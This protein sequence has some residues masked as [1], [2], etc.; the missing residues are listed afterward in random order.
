M[1]EYA[2]QCERWQTASTLVNEAP[3][4]RRHHRRTERLCAALKRCAAAGIGK[5]MEN[6]NITAGGRH[7][8]PFLPVTQFFNVQALGRL[9][10]FANLMMADSQVTVPA[11]RKPA[12][13]MWLSSCRLCNGYESLTAV[14]QKTQLARCSADFEHNLVS[15][16]IA[17]SSAFAKPFHYY[18][19]DWERC[20]GHGNH[21]RDKT[22]KMGST[23]SLS[24][25]GAG[26]IEDEIEPVRSGVGAVCGVNLKSHT[27]R[28]TSLPLGVVA[29]ILRYGFQT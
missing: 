25:F 11:R 26:R 27:G 5:I 28:R 29:A 7:Q 10:A 21:T 4:T 20:A 9:T 22:I 19:G 6:T 8:T 17:S 3:I 13:C 14:A 23:P 16:V 1:L 24:A 18:G 2:K 15:A 12:D